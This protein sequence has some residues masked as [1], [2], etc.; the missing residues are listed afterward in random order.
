VKFA[1]T[2]A[3]EQLELDGVVAPVEMPAAAAD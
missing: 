1:A 3:G 2:L